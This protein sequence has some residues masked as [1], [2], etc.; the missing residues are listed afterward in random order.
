MKSPE[1]IQQIRQIPITEYLVSINIRPVQRA[2]QQF[3]YCSPI[4]NEKTPSFA[5]DPKKNVFFDW[6]GEGRGD[7]ISL[8]QY[9][10]K[11]TFL[12]ALQLLE[13]YLLNPPVT[14]FSFS[15]HTSAYENTGVSIINVRPLQHLALTQYVERRGISFKIASRYLREVNYK[16]KGKQYFAVGFPN[17][18]GGYEVR[19][20]YFKGSFSPKAITTFKVNDSKTV[21]LFEGFFD[22]LS[23]LEYYKKPTLPASVVILNSLTNLTKI[24]PDLKQYEKVSSFLDTDEAGRKAFSKIKSASPIATD[25]SKV[26]YG[27][28]D[29]NELLVS[30]L[31][32]N[33][34]LAT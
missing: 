23:A 9:V 16:I 32:S 19:N 29:F 3:F 26:Y 8:V 27:F 6:S 10:S 20:Q 13:N 34:I 31:S 5:V 28:K 4:T 12:D 2:G 33:R 7:I 17:D 22:F 14:S 11:C 25:F 24:L 18:L 30:N 15:G 1:I 21:L